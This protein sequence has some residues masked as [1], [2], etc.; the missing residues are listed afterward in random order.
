MNRRW[1]CDDTT[2]S[3]CESVDAVLVVEVLFACYEASARIAVPHGKAASIRLQSACNLALNAIP[4]TVLTSVTKRRNTF[5]VFRHIWVTNHGITVRN[6]TRI[7]TTS[8]DILRLKTVNKQIETTRKL[9]S[10][11]G[12]WWRQ[13]GCRGIR[14]TKVRVICQC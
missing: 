8:N 5:E 3:P 14:D 13:P 7:E 1:G 12:V 10:V 4:R 9:Y 6:N 2:F 11:S